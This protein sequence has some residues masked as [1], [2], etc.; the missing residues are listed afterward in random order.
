MGAGQGAGGG[1]R[2]QGGVQGSGSCLSFPAAQPAALTTR[3]QRGPVLPVPRGRPP[4][5]PYPSISRPPTTC[6]VPD[7]PAASPGP[8]GPTLLPAAGNVCV[9]LLK[10]DTGVLLWG[11][12]DPGG[13]LGLP[14]PP[15]MPTPT[16]DRDTQGEGL[17]LCPQPHPPCPQGGG[18]LE[19][20]G[21]TGRG[22]GYGAKCL[23]PIL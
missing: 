5:V 11:I 14:P 7:V 20:R 4:P 1:P 13:G 22:L 17:C 16:V 15:A 10:G 2:E 12:T 3:G 18:D 8:V 9:T 23:P 19:E 21:G 6:R